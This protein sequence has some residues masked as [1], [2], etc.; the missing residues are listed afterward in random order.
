MN[1]FSRHSESK[2]IFI[3]LIEHDID[4]VTLSGIKKVVLSNT[5]YINPVERRFTQGVQVIKQKNSSSM[6]RIKRAEHTKLVDP[7]YYRKS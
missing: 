2:L 6:I 3:E 7:E 1:K 5:V 4:L